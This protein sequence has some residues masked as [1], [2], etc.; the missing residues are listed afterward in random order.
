MIKEVNNLQAQTF[1][2]SPIQTPI[3][4]ISVHKNSIAYTEVNGKR[5]IEFTSKK[6][7]RAYLEW[8]LNFS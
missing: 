7:T 5:H 2:N 4:N 1:K 6:E 8:L 3:S